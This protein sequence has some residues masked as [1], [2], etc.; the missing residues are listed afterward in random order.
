MLECNVMDIVRRTMK[1]LFVCAGREG[2]SFFYWIR[3][4]GRRKAFYVMMT[5]IRLLLRTK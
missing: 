1:P 5:I 4:V 3:V 2:N